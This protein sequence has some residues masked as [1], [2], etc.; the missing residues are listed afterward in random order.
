MVLVLIP[1]ATAFYLLLHA[2]ELAA[3]VRRVIG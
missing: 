3:M 1:L 2:E